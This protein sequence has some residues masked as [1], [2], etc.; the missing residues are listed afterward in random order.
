MPTEVLIAGRNAIE[1]WGYAHIFKP[2][3]FRQDPERVHDAVIGL[4]ARLGRSAAGRA[5]TAACFNYANP[6]LGQRLLGIDFPNPVGLA[7]GFDK[8]AI[9]PDVLPAVGFGFMEM[10][11]I[12]ARPYAGNTGKRLA[13]LPERRSLVVNYGLANQGVEMIA[14]RLEG[15]RFAIPLGTSIGPTN[16]T[17][18]ARRAAA[19]EDY[20]VSYRRL[21]GIGDYTTL[22]L[23]CPNTTANQPFLEPTALEELLSE[24]EREPT[25]KPIFL[26]LSPDLSEERL[27]KLLAVAGAHRV[28]GIICT[29]L[30][31]DRSAAT[32]RSLDIPIKGGLSGGAVQALADHMVAK[33]RR[34]A[35]DRFV[36]IGCGGIFNADDAYRRIR[37]GANLLQM[38]TGM[39]YEGP[40]VVSMIN[41][42]LVRRMRQDGF[43][44][45]AQAVGT[46]AL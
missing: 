12:T 4:G 34:L 24:I 25:K 19:I 38:V 35:G 21:A 32:L 13:R 29:N 8:N 45:L 27:E 14:A 26:K 41:Q 31:K 22:N 40:E 44:S 7:A 36:I 37:L 15:R 6:L 46:D 18:T 10:G 43:T 11:T 30:T 1:H 16:D 20:L 3:A 42:G 39:I 23:S 5:V 2:L 33:V 9:L 28:S 17:E